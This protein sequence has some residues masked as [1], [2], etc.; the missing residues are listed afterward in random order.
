ME[1]SASLRGLRG[2]A[3]SGVGSLK[4]GL[5]T[6]S[7]LLGEWGKKQLRVSFVFIICHTRM[8]RVRA[9]GNSVNLSG[10]LSR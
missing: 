9:K 5:N 7:K 8:P 6:K 10:P 2:I 1:E 3:A 4:K